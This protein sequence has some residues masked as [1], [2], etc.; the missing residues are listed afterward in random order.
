[1]TSVHAKTS[2]WIDSLGELDPYAE[3]LAAAALELASNIDDP[4]RTQ[5]GTASIAPF[6][7][8]LRVTMEKLREATSAEDGDE[9]GGWGELH[10]VPGAG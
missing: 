6:V 2:D 4:P 9:E 3:V 1:M 5:S 7:N 8:A 10:L